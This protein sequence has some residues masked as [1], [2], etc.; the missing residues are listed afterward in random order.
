VVDVAAVRRAE[1]VDVVFRRAQ[2]RV[3]RDDVQGAHPFVAHGAHGVPAGAVG[4]AI[5]GDVFLAGLQRI[6]RGVVREVEEEGL[7]LS[8]A[9]SRNPS[10]Q[11]VRTSVL[12][13]GMSS[14]AICSPF[15]KNGFCH[16]PSGGM[17]Y[18]GC[19]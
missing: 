5:P 17:K 18:R 6:V 11:S 9:R 12:C 2:P 19:R 4:P 10:A 8:S 7:P 16:S 14:A 1:G 13:T 15:R 3:G